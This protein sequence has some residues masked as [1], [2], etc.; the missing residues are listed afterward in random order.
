MRIST[1]RKNRKD[2]AVRLAPL[3]TTLL[4]L[5]CTPILAATGANAA[6]NYPSRSITVVVPFAAGGP[7]DI[8]AR[9]L[10][11]RM[12]LPLGQ[13]IVVENVAGAAGSVGVGRVAHAPADGYTLSIG[14]WI[15]HVLNGA[16]YKLQYDV[17]D[18]EPIALLPSNP[19]LILTKKDLPTPDLKALVAWLKANPDKATVATAGM[20]SG[21]HLIGLNFQKA[22]GTSF[23][24]VPYRGGSAPALQDQ[25][26]GHIDLRFDQA[27]SSLPAIQ[28]GQIK[29]LAVTAKTRLASAPD[30]PTVDEAGLPGFYVSTWHALW[31]PKGTPKTVVATLNAAVVEALADPTVRLRLEELGQDIPPRERQTPEALADH[32]KAEIETWWPII[33]AQNISAQ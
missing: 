23:A 33:K 20:G 7:T 6:D 17:R 12:K 13:P 21:G 9:S 18:F 31:A 22:T 8:I 27:A 15:T 10:I 30:I 11:E 2:V 1:D 25:I 28:A 16:V 32:H 26:A 3:T 29:A 4:A 5:A 24:F 19:Y 14:H